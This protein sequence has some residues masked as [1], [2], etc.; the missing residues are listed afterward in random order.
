MSAVTYRVE[1]QPSQKYIEFACIQSESSSMLV[2]GNIPNISDKWEPLPDGT[3]KAKLELLCSDGHELQNIWFHNGDSKNDINYVYI[4]A[5][6]VGTLDVKSKKINNRM[7]IGVLEETDFTWNGKTVIFSDIEK[8][9]FPQ[10]NSLVISIYIDSTTASL[11]FLE[12]PAFQDMEIPHIL[13]KWMKYKDYENKI[14]NPHPFLIMSREITVGEFRKYVESLDDEQRH[15]LGDAWYRKQVEHQNTTIFFS[16]EKPVASV[17]WWAANG[18]A[19]WFSKQNHCVANLPT[20]AQWKAAVVF[21]GAKPK[22]AIVRENDPNESSSNEPYPG[23][24]QR[25]PNPKNIEDLL[26]NLREWSADEY[27]KSVRVH[28]VLGEDYQTFR[29]NIAGEPRPYSDDTSLEVIGFR[30]VVIK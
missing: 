22:D 5:N 14:S 27:T 12:I 7:K 3:V 26:G 21:S 23:I 17:P 9:N 1:S 24:F 11:P 8:T 29:Y 16:D 15:K 6:L 28:F 13:K 25:D 19:E 20:I 4:K 2:T 10:E 30:L 18:Y